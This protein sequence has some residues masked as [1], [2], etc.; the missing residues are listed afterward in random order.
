MISPTEYS[1]SGAP[2]VE[3]HAKSAT[4]RSGKTPP[5]NGRAELVQ[6]VMQAKAGDSGAQ[7]RLLQQYQRR[8]AGFVR[9][10]I[11]QTAAVEDVTQVV[12]IKMF[13]R[14]DELREAVTFETWLFT[15]ARNSSL[16]FLRRC[17]CRPSTVPFDSDVFEIADPCEG[18]GVPEI[19]AALD[20]ALSHAKP[21]DA[22][23][24]RQFVAGQSYAEISGSTGLTV[25]VIKARLH[26]LRPFL[27]SA[28]SGMTGA[29]IRP[30]LYRRANVRFRAS[31]LAEESS[32]AA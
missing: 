9:G 11:R 7:K 17:A 22:R 1:C 19:V 16:D 13:R 20:I 2:S 15:L 25:V 6:L 24:V 12:F 8:V 31:Q 23:I 28:I 29:D 18:R 14:L 4:S 26:R 10:I 21:I 30:R 27:R 3:G 32:L 5:D